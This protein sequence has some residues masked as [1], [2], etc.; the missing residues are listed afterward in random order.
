MSTSL[1]QNHVLQYDGG[2]CIREALVILSY[3]NSNTLYNT[4]PPFDRKEV[5]K[6]WEILVQ[7]EEDSTYK[8]ELLISK[9]RMSNMKNNKRIVERFIGT[10][11]GNDI[12][13]IINITPVFIHNKENK[14]IDDIVDNKIKPKIIFESNKLTEGEKQLFKIILIKN[15]I[16]ESFIGR[17]EM[18][19]F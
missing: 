14:L 18:Y 15:D 10:T 4:G 12:I 3:L 17:L 16:D 2:D 6:R 9:G 7:L 1:L 13:D 19:E 11:K 5:Y 8:T